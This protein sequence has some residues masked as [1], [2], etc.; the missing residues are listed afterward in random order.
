MK[1]TPQSEIA[2]K[3]KKTV[4]TTREARQAERT[5]AIWVLVVSGIAAIVALAASYLLL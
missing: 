4:L 5:G 1:N 3:G 2:D